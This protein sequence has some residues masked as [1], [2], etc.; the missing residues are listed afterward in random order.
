MSKKKKTGKK[1]TVLYWIAGIVIL[2]PLAL[3][4]YIYFGAKENSGKPTVGNRFDNSLNPAITSEQLDKL[5]SSLK[6]DGVDNVEVNLI[7]ATLRINIDTKDDASSDTV[8]SIM[9]EAYDDVNK[10]L[11]IDKY[12]TNSTK[13]ENKTDKMYD[14]EVH[15]YNFIPDESHSSDDQ[16]YMVKTKTAAAKKANV[17]TPSSPKNKSVAEKLLKEQE[18]A[19]KKAK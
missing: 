5:K 18:E 4:I 15:V 9:N 14:L 2:I 16:I 19:A 6:F 3:L 11:P 1:S 12:F 13:S 10:T 8:K 7:S 17:S